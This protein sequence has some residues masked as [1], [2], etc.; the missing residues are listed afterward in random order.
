MQI[1]LKKIESL[2]K[3]SMKCFIQ[4]RDINHPQGNPIIKH[5]WTQF[6]LWDCYNLEWLLFQIEL[7]QLEENG[8]HDI[9]PCLRHLVSHWLMHW[10]AGKF[11]FADQKNRCWHWHIGQPDN[12]ENLFLFWINRWRK[13]GA[14]SWLPFFQQDDLESY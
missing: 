13:H 11:M 5:D 3:H 1:E 10:L 2:E 7:P 6:L 8:C 9:E 12:A 4:G 14:M